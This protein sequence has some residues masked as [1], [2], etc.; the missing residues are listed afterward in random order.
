LHL[1]INTAFLNLSGCI[2][3]YRHTTRSFVGATVIYL[4]MLQMHCYLNLLN[5][6]VFYGEFN[7]PNNSLSK[8]T[9]HAI[10]MW[11]LTID[12]VF[13][14][15]IFTGL[16]SRW[17]AQIGLRRPHRLTADIMADMITMPSWQRWSYVIILALNKIT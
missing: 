17:R 6:F 5:R 7:Y 10:V 15:K 2:I 4:Q 14:R 16:F 9:V 8:R 11:L 3:S 12:S 13:V 1:F